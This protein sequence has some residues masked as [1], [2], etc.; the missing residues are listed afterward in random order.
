[1]FILLFLNLDIYLSTTHIVVGDLES[2]VGTFDECAIQEN[3][4]AEIKLNTFGYDEIVKV[5]VLSSYTDIHNI[6]SN[7]KVKIKEGFF[8]GYRYSIKV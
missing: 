4:I 3:Y 6:N 5:N 8:F 1:M 2:V 7:V